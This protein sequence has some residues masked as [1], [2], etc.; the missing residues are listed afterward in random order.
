MIV[1]PEKIYND[2]LAIFEDIIAID[3]SH[4][5][6]IFLDLMG[7]LLEYGKPIIVLSYIR[8]LKLNDTET[9]NKSCGLLDRVVRYLKLNNEVMGYMYI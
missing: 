8:N 9:K 6:T 7:E 3:K 1:I 4:V 2:L 5:Q